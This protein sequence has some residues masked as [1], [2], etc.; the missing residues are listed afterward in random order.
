MSFG[1]DF[2]STSLKDFGDDESR[3]FIGALI[4]KKNQAGERIGDVLIHRVLR[5]AA[6]TSSIEIRKRGDKVISKRLGIK[7]GL[8]NVY[9]ASIRT[10]VSHRKVESFIAYR[11]SSKNL[12]SL[13]TARPGAKKRITV[14]AHERSG[15]PVESYKQRHHVGIK[16]IGKGK[17]ILHENFS[18]E[19]IA[20]MFVMQKSGMVFYNELGTNKRGREFFKPVTL[21]PEKYIEK[22]DLTEVFE[23]AE[24]RFLANIRRELRFAIHE[25]KTTGTIRRDVKSTIEGGFE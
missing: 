15:N 17:E 23:Y 10:I 16:S 14:S 5:R 6:R 22:T 13:I 1:K 24:K 18:K 2:A 12:G 4:G 19:E 8:K 3:G 11:S 21:N 7:T 9:P 20:K 25:L